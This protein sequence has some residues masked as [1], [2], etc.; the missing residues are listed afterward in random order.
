ML[1]KYLPQRI[2]LHH[3]LFVGAS[4]RNPQVR[5]GDTTVAA[6]D[7]TVDMRSNLIW[8]WRGGYGTWI[9]DGPRVNV[10]DNLYAAPRASAREQAQALTVDRALAYVQGNVSLD[11][12]AGDLDAESTAGA[13]FPAPVVERDAACP[14]A[15]RVVAS[16]GPQPLDPDDLR[17]LEPIALP[18]CP[19]TGSPAPGPAP[20]GAGADLVVS[21]LAASG[22]VRP[23]AT[24]TV[25]ATIGNVGD[26]SA[27]ATVTRFFLSP[28]PSLA[29]GARLL[30][31]Q[32]LGSLPGGASE[33][34][35][36]A[37]SL[38]A[39]LGDG[40]YYLV[41][42]TDAS[43][44]V[45][46]ANEANNTAAIG[47]TVAQS[48]P[49]GDLVVAALTAQGPAAPGGRIAVECTVENRGGVRIKSPRL[50]LF[51]AAGPAAGDTLLKTRLMQT[52]APGGRAVLRLTVGIPDDTPAG[53][54]QLVAVLDPGDGEPL[55][56]AEI[57]LPIN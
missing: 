27:G 4:Q 31:E 38:P 40:A 5:M 1:I 21:T 7:T 57:P 48:S 42:A 43:G 46:E 15:R 35:S 56:T 51:L 26:A 30:A 18:A 9:A 2:T 41:A 32:P 14:A 39:D 22:T 17:V 28:A 13:P 19:G 36:R 50:H 25:A 3:N 45:A 24:I 11:G 20:S 29:A 49:A 47:L 34:A 55:S 10:V 44:V 33:A 12:A 53:P 23:G 16:A 52:L 6:V 8:D 37:V 54:G